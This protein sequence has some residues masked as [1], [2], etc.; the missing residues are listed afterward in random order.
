MWIVSLVIG[1]GGGLGLAF[2]VGPPAPKNIIRSLDNSEALPTPSPKIAAGKLEV[3]QAKGRPRVEDREA[4]AHAL[5]RG[6]TVERPAALSSL[7]EQSRL[8][9]S[10]DGAVLR[11]DGDGRMLVGVS[12]P[13]VQL[14]SGRLFVFAESP[15]SVLL[16]Q[17][18]MRIQGRQFAVWSTLNTVELAV[19]GTRTEV[20]DMEG[21]RTLD[22]SLIYSLK[23]RTQGHPISARLALTD[24]VVKRRSR[25]TRVVGKT[26][27]WAHVFLRVIESEA[28]TTADGDGQFVL[29]VPEKSGQVEL[30]ATDIFGRK[31]RRDEPSETLEEF[32]TALN[33]LVEASGGTPMRYIIGST[34][35]ESIDGLELTPSPV[36]ESGPEAD[37]DGNEQG[38][39]QISP[40]RDEYGVLA[41]SAGP[42]AEAEM[43]ANA[44]LPAEEV[45]AEPLVIDFDFDAEPSEA[46]TATNAAGRDV[47]SG[48]LQ[49][50]EPVVVS[51]TESR[52][53]V[54]DGLT[55]RR[56]A[57]E[58]VGLNY[59]GPGIGGTV[60]IEKK[61]VV[62]E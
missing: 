43:V 52:G 59:T 33:D 50:G 3:L 30:V 44:D 62:P 40:D 57:P 54:N 18:G 15:Y 34:T 22:S 14:D 17:H 5:V 46:E 48:V 12:G 56:E 35:S 21:R 29:E 20:I 51:S 41:G 1:A 47:S 31:A 23:G 60:V 11:L 25:K 7:G 36:D 24:V 8:T 9:V 39:L 16:P 26:A 55:R 4:V 6:D 28:E 19:L 38:R 45:E 32:I 61:E 49:E 27:P 10:V 58:S 53:T 42:E 2:L 13:R 37:A